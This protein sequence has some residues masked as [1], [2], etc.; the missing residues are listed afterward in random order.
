MGRI[1]HKH[2]IDPRLIQIPS[3]FCNRFAVQKHA[4]AENDQFRPAGVDQ[5]EGRRDIDLVRVLRQ[6][7]KICHRRPFSVGIAGDEVPKRAHRL[8]A[9]M[10]APSLYGC[11]VRS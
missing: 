5:F 10:A 7:G 2:R 9:E 6:H 4:L 11:S 1:V 3:D 8:R